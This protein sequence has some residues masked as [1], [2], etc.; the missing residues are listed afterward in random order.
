MRNTLPFMFQRAPWRY[1][2]VGAVAASL[3]LGDVPH[4]DAVAVRQREVVLFRPAERLG[5]PARV[6]ARGIEDGLALP[7]VE[8]RAAA[9]GAA[10]A[11]DDG[12]QRKGTGQES[13]HRRLD[14]PASA[15]FRLRRV[16]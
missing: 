12:Q 14:R 7:L 6:V 3:R 5:E 15:E 16:R 8:G 1:R 9:K 2:T 4:V 10:E 13:Q 11:E